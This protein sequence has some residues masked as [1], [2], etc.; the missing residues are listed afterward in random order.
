VDCTGAFACYRA[1]EAS[2][3]LVDVTGAYTMTSTGTHTA[4]AGVVAGARNMVSGQKQLET[5]VLGP[6]TIETGAVT[7]EC[8]V[9]AGTNAVWNAIFP[10]LSL[11]EAR[12][13]GVLAYHFQM[14]GDSAMMSMQAA[15]GANC[16]G[17]YTASADI[18]TGAP[19]NGPKIWRH[20]AWT[21]SAS[22]ATT[23]KGYM[24]GAYV[25][26]MTDANWVFC[27]TALN[28]NMCFGGRLQQR[29]AGSYSG[30]RD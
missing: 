21:R 29:H 1:D 15:V 5:W 23:W 14:R 18:A 9:R 26:S 2:G 17:G 19:A 7:V 6:A 8:W 10:V 13:N 11:S 30:L 22:D 12:W 3:D 4:D 25:G 20:W 24:D 27:S 28:I 16:Q